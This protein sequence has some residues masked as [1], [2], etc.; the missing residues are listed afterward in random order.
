MLFNSY[1]F[2]LVYLPLVLAIYFLLIRHRLVIGSKVWL[3]VSSLFFYGWWDVVYLP[4][5]IG[6][7]LVNYTVGSFLP[8][9][10]LGSVQRKLILTLGILF[11]VTLLGYFKYTDFFIANFNFAF[12][13]SVP[14]QNIILPLAISYFTFQQI[15]YIVD[16]YR[17]ET[18]EYNFINYC[19]FISF[20]PQLL[21]GPI[22]HHKEMVPQFANR[23]KLVFNIN[24]VALGL[25]IF[26]IGLAKK[27]LLGDP[28]TDYAQAS[29]ANAQAMN[30]MEAWLASLSYVLSY[31]F[32]LSGYADMAIG[33]AKMFNI[34]LPANFNSPYKAR[35]FAEYWRRW[36]MTLSRFLGDYI[37]KSLGG[38][39][40]LRR[41]MYVN[42]MITF[43]VSGMWH[44]AGWTFLV[45][46]LIN[47]FFV[48]CS[49]FMRHN[50]LELN[51]YLAWSLTFL[52]VIL[53]RILFVANDFSDAWYV[54]LQLF[55]VPELVGIG[56]DHIIANYKQVLLVAIALGI[57][58]GFKNSGEMA[59]KFKPNLKYALFTS[60]LLTSSVLML[61]QASEFLYF[62]F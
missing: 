34:N 54:S 52:G 26:S 45:W 20:F 1:E 39:Q 37:Y 35:N 3:I 59:E 23:F 40:K 14:L 28:L 10:L 41:V 16:S 44:G 33:I 22:V 30:S 38:N 4:L 42:I 46:G 60:V 2:L 57:S 9:F 50:K 51:F 17:G 29:Y 19:L 58:L 5:I 21:M 43:F 31:Y 8:R 11:N 55:N 6:S 48:V 61:S 7:I 24:N 47:G 49:H 27:S 62:Q 13:T 25:F 36:H 18:K 53:T 32:D 56:Y 12:D 15:A